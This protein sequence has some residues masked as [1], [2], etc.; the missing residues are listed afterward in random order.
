MILSLPIEHYHIILNRTKISPCKIEYLISWISSLLLLFLKF[1]LHTVEPLKIDSNHY[2]Q[3]RYFLI[4]RGDL[5][6][7]WHEYHWII[8]LFSIN[9]A[10]SYLTPLLRC[11]FLLW[12]IALISFFLN[13]CFQNRIEWHLH[14]LL[15]KKTNSLGECQF[16][17][18]FI[19][20]LCI[21]EHRNKHFSYLPMIET[22]LLYLNKHPKVSHLDLM[23]LLNHWQLVQMLL[24]MLVST[25]SH[26]NVL[27]HD[28]LTFRLPYLNQL[29]NHLI[30][31]TQKEQFPY[32]IRDWIAHWFWQPC[33][34]I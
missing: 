23:L 25:L 32:K 29:G 24:Y 30:S 9:Q 5:D 12:N 26:R 13:W 10:S 20:I 34:C 15:S 6:L 2:L 1:D 33:P 18:Q 16:V 27:L 4:T 3:L 14:M 17:D 28:L 22:L 21:F 7:Q 11:M 31:L 19:Y 8:L